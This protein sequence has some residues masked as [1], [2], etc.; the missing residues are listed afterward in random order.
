MRM[1]IVWGLIFFLVTLPAFAAP[2]ATGSGWVLPE[3]EKLTFRMKWIGIPAGVIT[4]EI[5][6]IEE[7]HGR[8]AYRIEVTAKTTGLCSILYRIEDRYVSYLDIERLHTLRHEVHRREGGYKKD[9]VTDFDQDLHRAHFKSLSD[10]SEKTFDI[11]PD[12]QDTISAA[13]VMRTR[14]FE[15][16]GSYGVKICNSEKNYDILLNVLGTGVL[17][18]AGRGQQK[19]FS[20]KPYGHLNGKEVRD[21]R[22]SGWVSVEPGHLPYRIVIKAPVFTQVSAFLVTK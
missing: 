17:S 6:G 9:A 22:M 4:A 7:I 3:T 21:G 15:V 20:I 10:G 8:R 16:G 18:V 11:P 12:A 2:S 1:K 19:V 13:Y 14:A 5:K